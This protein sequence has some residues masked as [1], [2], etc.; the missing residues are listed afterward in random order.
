MDTET[1][2]TGVRK[3]QET[4]KCKLSF[5]FRQNPVKGAFVSSSLPHHMAFFLPGPRIDELVKRASTDGLIRPTL[6]EIVLLGCKLSR[7]K[8]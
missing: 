3:R 8:C 6:Y 7:D 4:Y 5:L 2:S 1:P